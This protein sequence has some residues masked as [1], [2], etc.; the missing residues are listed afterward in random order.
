MTVETMAD[1]EYYRTKVILGDGER[2]CIAKWE[3]ME[4]EFYLERVDSRYPATD[5]GSGLCTTAVRPVFMRA[6]AIKAKASL[7]FVADPVESGCICYLK[8]AYEVGYQEVNMYQLGSYE[9]ESTDA[10]LEF[11]EQNKNNKGFY[12]NIWEF[13]P[14]KE[15]EER[16][17][18]TTVG[19]GHVGELACAVVIGFLVLLKSRRFLTR[20]FF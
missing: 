5:T 8:V 20:N 15:K 2:Q 9:F 3:I 16:R 18:F 14:P 7:F 4:D 17:L 10:I 6:F 11:C 13:P 1:D 12:R 19:E